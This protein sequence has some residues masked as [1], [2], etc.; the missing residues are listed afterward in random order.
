MDGCGRTGRLTDAFAFTR[1]HHLTKAIMEVRLK[2]GWL[3]QVRSGQVEVII[4]IVLCGLVKLGELYS[5]LEY[6]LWEYGVEYS[7]MRVG[8]RLFS[9]KRVGYHHPSWRQHFTSNCASNSELME[10]LTTGGLRP[11]PINLHQYSFVEVVVGGRGLLTFTQHGVKQV[12]HN[13]LAVLS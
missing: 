1:S 4:V 9:R 6:R 7:M 12:K 3:G 10:A 13:S 8:Y 11:I 5:I 2:E